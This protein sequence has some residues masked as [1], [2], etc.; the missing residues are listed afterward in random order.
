MGLRD[1]PPLSAWLLP[2]GGSGR[3]GKGCPHLSCGPT[4]LRA[5][6]FNDTPLWS[7]YGHAWGQF[8]QVPVPSVADEESGARSGD[9]SGVMGEKRA[10]S[11]GLKRGRWQ[12]TST[13]VLDHGGVT[14]Q[15]WLAT[16]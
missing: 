6:F 9:G 16:L 7:S 1:P 12:G 11:S 8:P 15:H 10:L 2:F 14:F 13:Q 5:C 4:F 3:R